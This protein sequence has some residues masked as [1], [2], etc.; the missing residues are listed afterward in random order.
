MLIVAIDIRLCLL[1]PLLCPLVLH[2]LMRLNNLN[3]S[4]GPDSNTN[5][6]IFHLYAEYVMDGTRF[7]EHFS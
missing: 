1:R 6:F 2:I 7:K 5:C 3:V 4:W